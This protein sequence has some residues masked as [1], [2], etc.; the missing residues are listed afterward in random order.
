MLEVELSGSCM[1]VGIQL[2]SLQIVVLGCCLA[3]ADGTGEVKHCEYC[4]ESCAEKLHGKGI[5][6]ARAASSSAAVAAHGPH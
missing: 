5:T 1:I 2:A 4:E 6:G 3:A